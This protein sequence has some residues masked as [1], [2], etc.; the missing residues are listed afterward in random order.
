MT[1]PSDDEMRDVL[2]TAEPYTVL[3]LRPGPRRRAEGTDT[4]LWEHGRRNM[5]LRA[6]GT[7]AIVIPI[8]DSEVSG[9]GILRGDI[10][11]ARAAMADDPGIR[12]GVFVAELHAGH[13]FP[14]ESL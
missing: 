9:I 2:Q 4:I 8:G 11:S 14:G 1:N 12:A 7:L 3:I 6:E 10:E 13:S 5:R